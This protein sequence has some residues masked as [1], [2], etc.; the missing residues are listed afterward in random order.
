MFHHLLLPTDGSPLSQQAVD[1][2][3]AF[4][5]EHG[6]QVTIYHAIDPLPPYVWSEGV[7]LDAKVIDRAEEASL[8]AGERMVQEAAATAQGAG[9]VCHVDV[10]RAP[11]PDRGILDAVRRHHCDSIFMSSHGRGALTSLLIGSVT[12][13]VL[14]SA[15]VPVVVYR[16]GR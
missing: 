12:L 14:S 1:A 6:S 16:A 13:K 8:R 10:D 3:I 7:A 11:S 5:M 4:A 9:V 2:G 15:D